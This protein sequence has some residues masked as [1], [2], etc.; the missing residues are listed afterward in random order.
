MSRALQLARRGLFTTSPNPRVGCVLVR[1][2]EV[3]GEGWHRRAGEPHAE[4]I[5]IEAARERARGADCYV[6]LEP[7]AHDGRTP[8]CATA[9]AAAGIRRVVAAMTDPNPLVSGRGMRMIAD[10][11]ITAGSGLLEAEAAALNPG[12]VRRMREQRPWV[13]CKIALS[14]DGRAAAAD[15]SSRW[16]TSRPAREDVQRLRAQSCAVLTGVGTVLAD[17]PQLNVR[18]PGADARQPLRVVLDRGLRFPAA[19][20]MCT[21]PGRT[22]VFTLNAVPTA[23][24]APARAGAEVIVLGS[25]GRRRFLRNVLGHLAVNEQVNEVLVEAGP[26]LA[27]GLLAAG[28]VDELIVYQAPVL[29]GHRGRG[30]LNLPGLKTIADRRELRLIETRRIGPDLRLT[31]RC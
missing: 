4:V 25:G 5:A 14:L 3:V 11:G 28:L 22:L 24:A 29:L 12:F 6:T 23:A 19:A 8:P 18:L 27:G 20:R 16:I 10:A 30:A 9:V 26:R 2:G 17:D 7:C 15:G 21:L 13:R 31:F 1:N